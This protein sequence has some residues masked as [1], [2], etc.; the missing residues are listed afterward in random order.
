MTKNLV[1]QPLFRGVA[2]KY[3]LRGLIHHS[4][5]DNQYCAHAYRKLLDQFGMVALMSHRR[6]CYDNVLMESFWGLFKNELVHHRHFKTCTEAIQSIAEYIEV[7]YRL[8]CK[9]AQLGYLPPAAF[10]RQFYE[11]KLAALVSLLI[12]AHF[13]SIKFQ[14]TVF[15]W[16]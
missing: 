11:K 4:D 9:Q 14:L 16:K 13:D 2:V 8:Q 15:M 5:R 1:S 7:F 10:E 3:P 6:N 12:F